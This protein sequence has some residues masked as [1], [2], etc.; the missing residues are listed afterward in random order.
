MVVS[1]SRKKTTMSTLAHACLTV[2]Q[3]HH[4]SLLWPSQCLDT[5]RDG[6]GVVVG[7]RVYSVQLYGHEG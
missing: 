6:G 3:P 5:A 1:A 2:L 4:V 7:G